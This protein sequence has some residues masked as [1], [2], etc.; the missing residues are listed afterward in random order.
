MY[1]HK[2]VPSILVFVALFGLISTVYAQESQYQ[3]GLRG[4][5]LLGDGVPA[6]DILGFG[7]IGRYAFRDG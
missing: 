3:I 2:K 7:V 1:G 4:N 5:V 6:N